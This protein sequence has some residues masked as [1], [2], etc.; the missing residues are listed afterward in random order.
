MTKVSC[1]II[2]D[3]LPLYIDEVVSD[4]TRV[5]VVEH[6]KECK[7]CKED[8]EMMKQDLY[9]PIEKDVPVIK[10]LK[11]KWRN[12]KFLVSGLSILLTSLILL[13]TH[14]FIFHYDTFIPY[15]K[16]LVQIEKQD[17]GN[18]NAHY[19]GE[20]FYS[21]N[22]TAPMM[23]TIDGNEKRAIFIYYTKT[24]SDN[25]TRELFSGN[26]PRHE[27]DFLF[28]L[29]PIT[30]V[31]VVYYVEFDTM[32]VFDNGGNWEEVA[33]R[34]ELIWEKLDDKN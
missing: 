13:S 20:S 8:V 34:A 17:N 25:P 26:K 7:D 12:K 31:D 10:N 14:Y 28:Q 5:M 27:Q 29:A 32:H 11:K 18:L 6:L 22:A 9:L 2:Q 23:V 33:D 15:S 3:V 30:D 21:T 19:Y 4:E 16:S 24:I 1:P